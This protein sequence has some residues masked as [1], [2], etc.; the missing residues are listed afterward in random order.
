MIGSCAHARRAFVDVQKRLPRGKSSPL[1]TGTLAFID[2]LHRAEA[3]WRKL[4]PDQCTRRRQ[5]DTR[6]V[7]A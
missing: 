7:L 2:K 5:C 6:L 1:A 4:R 3:R